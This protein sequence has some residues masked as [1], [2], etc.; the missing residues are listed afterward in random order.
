V[1]IN[2]LNIIMVQQLVVSC[3]LC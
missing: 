2:Y 1:Q 3:L